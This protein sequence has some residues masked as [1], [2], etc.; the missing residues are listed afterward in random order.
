MATS[1]PG[2]GRV[3]MRWSAATFAVA[4]VLTACTGSGSHAQPSPPGPNTLTIL[5]GSELSDLQPLVA[6]IRKDTGLDLRFEYSGS[7]DGAETIVRGTDADLAWFSNEKYIDLAGGA[8]KVLDRQPIMLSP[9]VVGVKQSL[10][11]KFGW[12][13]NDNVTWKM[14]AAKA[15]D[16]EFRYAMTNPAA[17]NTGFSALV[18]VASAYAGTGSA[19][20]SKEIDVKDLRAFFSGQALTAGSSGFLADAYVRHQD[21]L[22]GMINY[23]SVLL[24]LNQSGQLHEPLYLVYPRDGIVTADYPLMLLNPAKRAQY[25]KLVNELRSPAIQTW[26]MTNTNRRPA[27]PGVPLDSRF[28]KRVLVELAFPSS[29]EVVRDLLSAYLNELAKPSHTLFVL[30]VSGSMFGTRINALKK[31]M[32]GLAGVDNSVTGIFSQFRN[33]EDVTIITFSSSVEGDRDFAV[34]GT[35]PNS[36]SLAAIREYV[37]GLSAGGNTAIYSAL[38]KAYTQAVQS[39]TADPNRFTSIVLMT[40][41]MNNSGESPQQF[42]A[43]LRG[44]GPAAAQ[45]PTYAVI[46]G[47]ASPAALTQIADETGGKVFDS[48]SASLSEVF[49]EIRGYQ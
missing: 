20:T 44:L 21:D 13:G 27:V 14:I 16:G 37:D 32:D 18:G 11:K 35:D 23:E 36:P 26:L 41:G 24:S 4:L 19:L 25:E 28:P 15:D 39:E 2:K 40:D 8:A 43:D 38:S 10:A 6:R 5:A 45:I 17:S 31:A 29:L 48:R 47:E 30:D 3:R 7:L 33:R 1:E 49:K 12:V 9:V 42:M 34:E 22:D 46:F